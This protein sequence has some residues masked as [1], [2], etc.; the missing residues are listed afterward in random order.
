MKEASSLFYLVLREEEKNMAKLS[1]G[2][3]TGKGRLSSFPFSFW[4]CK[5]WATWFK[6]I[7]DLPLTTLKSLT[8]F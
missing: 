8:N 4:K 7:E 5:D 3:I 2:L 6:S 1:S